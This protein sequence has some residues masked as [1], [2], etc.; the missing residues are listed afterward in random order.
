M[1]SG[2]GGVGGAE[3]IFTGTLKSHFAMINILTDCCDCILL[4]PV[5]PQE[6]HVLKESRSQSNSSRKVWKVKG[7]CAN[8]YVLGVRN[9]SAG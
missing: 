9:P 6:L 5:Y 4:F 8:V 1:C 7:D 2:D 3:R